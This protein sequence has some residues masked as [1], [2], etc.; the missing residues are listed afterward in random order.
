[1]VTV[2]PRPPFRFKSPAG[3]A[4]LAGLVLLLFAA[5]SWLKGLATRPAETLPDLG[6]APAFEARDAGGKRWTGRDLAG[7]IWIADAVTADC[8]GCLVRNLRMTDLQ[9]SFAKAGVLLVTFVADPKIRP[10]ERL[11]ELARTFGAAPGRWIFVAG[12]PPFAGDRFILVDGAGR[13]RASVPDSDAALSSR[14]L[15]A[16]GDLLRVG[17]AARFAGTAQ[18]PTARSSSAR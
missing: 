5:G 2:P 1:M 14:L 13:L 8:G 17:R 3:A 15:D 4:I 7:K 6:A 18:P 12:D 10:P 9:T 11:G 16:V